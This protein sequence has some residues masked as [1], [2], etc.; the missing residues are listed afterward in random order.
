MGHVGWIRNDLGEHGC[1]A[2]AVSLWTRICTRPRDYDGPSG[3]VVFDDQT[4]ELCH[5]MIWGKSQN[6]KYA[7]LACV[8][9]GI[10]AG[11]GRS[12]KWGRGRRKKRGH[13][14]SSGLPAPA[15]TFNQSSNFASLYSSSLLNRGTVAIMLEYS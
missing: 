10:V 12:Y 2:K 3:S 11:S 6:G 4:K 14:Q 9:M 7:T 13:T 1:L 8:N 5:E 15:M